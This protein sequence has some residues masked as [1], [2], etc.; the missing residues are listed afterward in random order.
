MMISIF[1]LPPGEHLGEAE[2]AEGGEVVSG[3]AA[4][5]ADREAATPTVVVVGGHVIV[6]RV[7]FHS[8]TNLI[9]KS[10]NPWW[11]KS[12]SAS[13]AYCRVGEMQ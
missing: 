12:A 1:V 10:L 5:E 8:L 4:V 6:A 13:T 2:E 11:C 9:W 7:V 3:A